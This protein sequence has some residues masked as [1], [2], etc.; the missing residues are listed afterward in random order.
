MAPRSRDLGPLLL[1]HDAVHLERVRALGPAVRVVV[2]GRERRIGRR[3]LAP[4]RAQPGMPRWQAVLVASGVMCG[5]KTARIVNTETGEIVRHRSGP[6]PEG[7]WVRLYCRQHPHPGQRGPLPHRCRYHGGAGR[8]ETALANR[9]N[10][11]ARKLGLYSGALT[12]ENGNEVLEDLR[13]DPSAVLSIIEEGAL[14]K[15]R[16]REALLAAKRQQQLLAEG[17]TIE[18]L[19]RELT[20]VR[21][22]EDAD[23]KRTRE[24]HA[25]DFL[26]HVERCLSQLASLLRVHSVLYP[27]K[28]EE[29]DPTEYAARVQQALKE[30]AEAHPLA[31]GFDDDGKKVTARRRTAEERVRRVTVEE[32]AVPRKR[33]AEGPR[34]RVNEDD[35]GQQ[36]GEPFVRG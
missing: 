18:D 15:A 34:R 2:P 12:T 20:Y 35:P 4:W 27:A 19:P 3:Q 29:S 32:V 16:I 11:N 28:S 21:W 6:M 8:E 23:G 22:R 17:S 24:V 9:G 30:M 31:E 14:L 26:D 5:A 33:P 13:G 25:T 36:L 7:P 1:P 10:E